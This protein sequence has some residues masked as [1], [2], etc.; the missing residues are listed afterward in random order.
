MELIYCLLVLLEWNKPTMHH[1]SSIKPCNV[2][3]PH[4]IRET[5]DELADWLFCLVNCELSVKGL[6]GMVISDCDPSD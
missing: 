3:C 4:K 6:N 2:P 1:A 5:D